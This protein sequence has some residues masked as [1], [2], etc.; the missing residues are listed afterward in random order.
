MWMFVCV[1]ECLCVCVYGHVC[2]MIRGP[3]WSIMC[4]VRRCVCVYVYIYIYIYVCIYIYIYIY[5]YERGC[6]CMRD[7]AGLTLKHQCMKVCMHTHMHTHMYSC[8]RGSW[9]TA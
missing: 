6:V 5:I 8:R 3:I 9:W 1:F 2:H 7:D 4:L